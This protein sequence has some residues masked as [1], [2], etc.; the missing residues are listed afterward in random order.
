MDSVTVFFLNSFRPPLWRVPITSNILTISYFDI[1]LT[2]NIMLLL[3]EAGIIYNRRVA[4]AFGIFRVQIEFDRGARVYVG[5]LDGH[6][7]TSVQNFSI[8]LFLYLSNLKYWHF[9]GHLRLELHLLSVVELK[10]E[11]GG[12]A[13]VKALEKDFPYKSEHF[14]LR[15][16]LPS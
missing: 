6:M 2:F 13:A 5:Y 16:G 14:L 11:V 3:I 9:V 10:Q 4:R 7:D 8:S 1:I 12:K 15:P